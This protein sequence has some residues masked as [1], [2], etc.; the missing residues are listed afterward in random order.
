[1]PKNTARSPRTGLVSLS[2][3][4]EEAFGDREAYLKWSGDLP[5]IYETQLW[6]AELM[7]LI[8]KI[9]AVVKV[10]EKNGL[11]LDSDAYKRIA[12]RFNHEVKTRAAYRLLHSELRIMFSRMRHEMSV[13]QRR[14][15]WDEP[16]VGFK[17]QA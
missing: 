4:S 16:L 2:E 1:M 12:S 17:L 10:A 9:K 15:R 3:I 11:H 7:V 6:G 13:Q 8:R 5:T 14:A